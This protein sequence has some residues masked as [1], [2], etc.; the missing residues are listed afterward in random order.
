[1]QSLKRNIM[2]T[3]LFQLMLLM[4][5]FAACKGDEYYEDGGLAQAK[6][7]GTV[8]QYLASKPVEFDTLVQVIKLAGMEQN[9]NNDE[10]TFFAPRDNSIK[11]MIG[12]LDQGGLNKIL[13]NEGRETIKVLADIDSLI[14]RKYL[15]RH[16]FKNKNKLM[17]YPQIDLAQQAIY[18]G[19]TY[20]AYDNT[21]CNIGVVYNDAG[22]IRYQ[23][24]RQL[25]ISYIP[26]VS[27]PQANWITVPVSSSDIEPFNGIV[28]ILDP[29]GYF[30]FSDGEMMSEIFDSKR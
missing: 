18:P 10:F 29:R 24:Y 14:W 3:R 15:Q 9:F 2:I 27:N 26:D 13:Y 23:G 6:F 22:G 19:Q 28:H 5:L 7:E 1:M 30:G 16:M 21:V 25:T 20:Y 17:D 8:M 4:I 11:S 12:R